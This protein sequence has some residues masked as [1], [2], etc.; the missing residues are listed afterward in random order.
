[1]T[2]MIY[3]LAGASLIS[4]FMKEILDA[5]A[6]LVVILLNAFIGF[7]TEFRAEKALLALRSMISPT[8]VSLG[9]GWSQD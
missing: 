5:T 9:G 7:A 2:P 4:L 8:A 6:I 1:M 3:L